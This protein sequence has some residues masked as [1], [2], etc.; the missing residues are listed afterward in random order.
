MKNIKACYF[1]VK[2]KV[3]SKEVENSYEPTKTMWVDVLTKPKQGKQFRV[4]H[5]NLMNCDKNCYDEVK[6]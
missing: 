2:E 4:L 5:A 3:L 1:L 6:K